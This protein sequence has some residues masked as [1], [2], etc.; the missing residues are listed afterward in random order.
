MSLDAHLLVDDDKGLRIDCVDDRLELSHLVLRDRTEENAGLFVRVSAVRAPGRDTAAELL[1]NRCFERVVLALCDNRD[2]YVDILG[3][4]SVFGDRADSR[5]NQR[6]DNGLR[7][8]EEEAD[9]VEHN[10][11]ADT[12]LCDAEILF[13]LDEQQRNDIHAARGCAVSKHNTEAEAGDQSADNAGGEHIVHHVYHGNHGEE[14]RNQ[15]G[16]EQ[17]FPKE[18]FADGAHRNQEHRKVDA[19]VNNTGDIKISG[20]E[21]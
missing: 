17:R 2:Q 12:D 7:V 3:V 13:P 4:H 21:V 5:A 8:E 14:E 10:V 19:V 6:I 9:A 20:V 18:F 15:R 1:Q 11:Y 16:R